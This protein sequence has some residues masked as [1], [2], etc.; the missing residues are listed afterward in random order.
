MYWW[1][2]NNGTIVLIVN[3]VAKS[4]HG[5]YLTLKQLANFFQSLISFFGIVCYESYLFVWNWP[6]HRNA[7]SILDT[8]GL[9]LQHQ[10]ISS[11]SADYTPMHFQLCIG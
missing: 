7:V 4:V 3:S 2:S 10:C 1:H 5:Q 6:D 8:D 11:H 9:V